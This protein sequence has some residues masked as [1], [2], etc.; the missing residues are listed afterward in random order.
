MSANAQT[1]DGHDIHG[2]TAKAVLNATPV[3]KEGK[4]MGALRSLQELLQFEEA[5]EKLESYSVFLG[6]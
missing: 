6:A 4:I 5:A 1:T 3:I 2:E